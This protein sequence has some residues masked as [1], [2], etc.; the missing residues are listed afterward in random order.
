MKR[1]FEPDPLHPLNQE[2]FL[3][4]SPGPRQDM[5]LVPLIEENPKCKIFMI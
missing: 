1:K 3:R 5:K 2:S 4:M